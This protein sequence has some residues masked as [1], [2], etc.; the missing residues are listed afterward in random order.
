MFYLCKT[1]CHQE[2]GFSNWKKALDKFQEHEAS[3]CHKTSVDYE[4]NIPKP[5]CNIY[6]VTSE[7]AKTTMS[8]EN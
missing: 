8:N 4:F 5:C 3:D 2:G 6:E 7:L 1:E